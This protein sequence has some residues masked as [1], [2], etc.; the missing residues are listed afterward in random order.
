MLKRVNKQIQFNTLLVR[1]GLALTLLLELL[2]SVGPLKSP[3]LTIRF[4]P[5]RFSKFLSNATGA[6]KPSFS[7]PTTVPLTSRYATAYVYNFLLYVA[8]TFIGVLC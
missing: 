8:V 6:P 4:R 2:L 1:I 3:V 5:I 7:L